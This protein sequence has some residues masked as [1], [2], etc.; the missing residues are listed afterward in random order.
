MSQRK[1]DGR[2]LSA[3]S[4]LKSAALSDFKAQKGRLQEELEAAAQTAMFYPKFHSE[5]NFIE[6]FW[7]AAKW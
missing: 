7:C 5:L 2:C 6:R 3:G 4:I 1:T